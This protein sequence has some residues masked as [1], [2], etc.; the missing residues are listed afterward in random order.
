MLWP[1]AYH[2]ATLLA[3]GRVLLA[4]GFGGRYGTLNTAELFDPAT[5]G[6]SQAAPMVAARRGHSA[7]LL[8]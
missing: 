2:T 4:G 7:T 1:R 5:G 6:L 3:D 8:R